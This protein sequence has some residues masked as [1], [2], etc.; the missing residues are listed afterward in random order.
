MPWAF[1]YE[2]AGGKAID[3]TQRVLD[4]PFHDLHQRN[5]LFIGSRSMVENLETYL[6]HQGLS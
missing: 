1:I 4:I 6:H 2:I 5:A 3:G